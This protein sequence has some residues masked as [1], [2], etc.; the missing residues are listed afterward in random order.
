VE[1]LGFW[2]MATRPRSQRGEGE[3]L[4]TALLDAATELLAESHDVDSLS[5]RA[6]TARAGVSPTALYLHF[7]DKQALTRAVKERCYEALGTA[8]RAAVA[9]HGDDAREQ[10]RAMGHA[11]L[12]FAREQPGQY[13][14][15][16]E[17]HVPKGGLPPITLGDPGHEVLDLVLGTVA[18]SVDDETAAFEIGCL[19]WM[20]LHGR[21]AIRAAMP[22]FPF[23]DD[24]R[25][26]ELLVERCVGDA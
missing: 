2:D 1:H 4:R 9:E 18:M 16:F 19:A 22:T 5:V 3:H 13:A 14:I 11:Y 10:M 26:V 20:A 12:R 24:E 23:P 7:A 17:T 15:L 25:F 21:A 8:L 6:V